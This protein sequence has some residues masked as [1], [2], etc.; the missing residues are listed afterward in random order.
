[1]G[2]A[3]VEKYFGANFQELA[4]KQNALEQCLHQH[5]DE[6]ASSTGR[7]DKA[8]TR[9][10]M[11]RICASTRER[12]AHIDATANVFPVE[13]GPQMERVR[14]IVRQEID[15]VVEKTC[16]NSSRLGSN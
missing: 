14:G 10:E 3:D 4:S 5:A 12:S 13:Q 2:L 7:T 15:N 11:S 9:N 16:L 6:L 1:M 8:D